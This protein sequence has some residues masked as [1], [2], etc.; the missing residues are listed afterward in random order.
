M[1]LSGIVFEARWLTMEQFRRLVER[2]DAKIYRA[3]QLS[4][5]EP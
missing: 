1:S 5:D 2:V 3:S 4:S